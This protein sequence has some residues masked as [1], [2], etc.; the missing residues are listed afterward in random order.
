VSATALQSSSRSGASVREVPLSR[1]LVAI[2]DAV[3]FERLSAYR[4]RAIRNGRASRTWYA[5][6]GNSPVVLMHNLVLPP[7]PGREIDHRDRN[8]LHNTRGNLRQATRG[9]NMANRAFRLGKTGYRGVRRHGPSW[10]AVISVDRRSVCSACYSTAQAAARAYDAMA[11]ELHGEFA[12]LNFP[13]GDET[14]RRVA[15][16]ADDLGDEPRSARR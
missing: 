3:D 1:G 6:T 8:G 13:C 9:Q 11:L 7:L 12:V 15:G 2:V 4:W 14:P 5:A 10:R 16:A